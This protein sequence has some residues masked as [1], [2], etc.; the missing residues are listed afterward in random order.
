M[1]HRPFLFH[2]TKGFS[3]IEVMIA[4]MITGI[5]TIGVSSNLLDMTR[6]QKASESNSNAIEVQKM[7][8]SS[9][10]GMNKVT[11]AA[12]TSVLSLTGAP[13]FG[14][15]AGVTNVSL[16]IPGLPAL[17]AGATITAGSQSFRVDRIYLSD[18]TPIST[19]PTGNAQMYISNLYIES[20]TGAFGS[21]LG[22]K[23]NI[24]SMTVT[25][26][27][28]V[29]TACN[30]KALSM[31]S[32]TMCGNMAGFVWNTASGK[33]T[34]YIAPTAGGGGVE[35]DCPPGTWRRSDN[36]CVPVASDCGNGR[37]A[38][39]FRLGLVSSCTNASIG[40][41][42]GLPAPISPPTIAP[43]VP[44][45]AASGA[46]S[47]PTPPTNPFTPPVASQNI[48][49]PTV[50]PAPPSSCVNGTTI[51]ETNY[52]LCE[53]GNEICDLSGY[54][55]V[56]NSCSVQE[57]LAYTTPNL[58]T[59]PP[60]VAPPANNTCMCNN[61]RIA[62]GEYC[63]Y[64]VNNIHFGWGYRNYTFGVS[65]CSAGV[66]VEIPNPVMNTVGGVF[67]SNTY[68]RAQRVGPVYEQIP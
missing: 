62:D 4:M 55:A 47:A 30:A 35:I 51:N 58:A 57:A 42:V 24:G 59:N 15:T 2:S 13:Q 16:A 9:F 48:S 68:G 32:A 28:G 63:M 5:L 65:Q 21:M 10:A 60:S 1:K 22:K 49:A 36:Q 3:L 26:E 41:A 44:S 7:I 31:N 37:V 61:R 54:T 14:T 18:N 67:C 19:A 17:Q 53:N 52:N 43:A 50:P 20:S 34:Q 64:C 27:N 56:D 66:L 46:P 25:L 38:K 29:L 45:Q 23:R 12:C 6:A 8:L 39:G 11:G 40:P 33:C